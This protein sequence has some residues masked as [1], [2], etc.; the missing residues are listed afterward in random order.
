MYHCHLHIVFAGQPC[1]TF[2]VVEAIAPPKAFTYA[3]SRV[4]EFDAPELAGADLILANLT[5]ADPAACVRALAAGKAPGAQLVV[6]AGREQTDALT[7]LLDGL[8]DLWPLPMGEQESRFRFQRWQKTCR[9]SKDL[10]QSEHFLDTLINSTPSMVWFKDK[11][12]LHQKVNDSFCRTVCKDK[13]QVE[14]RDHCYIW[15]VGPKEAEV[16]AVSDQAVM[17]SHSICVSEEHVQMGPD[18]HILT[19]YKAPLYDLDGSVMG[20]VGIGIDATAERDYEQ[21][22]LRKT[23]AL[24]AI[25]TTLK[26]GVLCHSLDGKRIL[27]INRAALSI[28]DYESQEEM[29]AAGFSTVAPSVLDEDKPKLRECIRSLKKEGDSVDIE[30]RVLHKDGKLLHVIGN[31]KLIREND[32]LC[33]QRFLLDVTEQKLREKERERHQAELIQA[34]ARDYELVCYFDLSSGHGL[35]L[36]ADEEKNR[37]TDNAFVGKVSLDE[38]MGKYINSLVH[39]ADREMMHRAVDRREILAQLE[40]KPIYY[41]NYRTVRRGELR[42]FT[43]KI[44]RGGRWGKNHGIVLGLRNVDEVTRKEMEHKQLLEDALTQANLANRAKSSFLSNMSHDIRTPINAIV[45]FTSLAISNIDRRD[46]LEDYLKKIKAS[47]AHLLALIND[48]LDMSRIESGRLKLQ[49]EPYKLSDILRDLCDIVHP[50]LELRQQNMRL[51]LSG[52]RDD[53]VIC[54]KL[55]LNRVLMNIL[56]NS[57]KYTGE[58]G[59]IELAVSQSPSVRPGYA[60]YTFRV[61]DNGIGMSKEFLAHIFDPFEREKNTTASG[62]QG[63]GLGMAITKN[64]VEMMKGTIEIKS[65]Q[66]VGTRV[67]VTFSF[68]VAVCDDQALPVAEP[69][70]PEPEP[71]ISPELCS[72]RILLVEDNDLNQQIG[73]AILENA[74]F[75]VELAENGQVS[76]DM[77]KAAEPGYYKLI[78]MDVQMPVM[79]GYEAARAIR[80]LPDKGKAS[81]PILAMTANAFEEDRQEAL[82]SG[83]NDHIAKPIDVNRLLIIMSRYLR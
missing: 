27:S 60:D 80:A 38:S 31:V 50:D 67:L 59:T 41:V 29:L 34:L 46:L 15:N 18:T 53:E 57:I 4:R 68:R 76:V 26:C 73:Q 7:G 1:L 81:I 28:L 77:L 25:F 32:E 43:M 36:R 52:V 71:E 79:N 70:L 14:G 44:V 30:Y 47:S 23:R 42:Y 78:L 40:K 19:V 48:V 61:T 64:L 74:G 13:S 65:R 56:S 9:M 58:G 3:F 20:T 51:N 8:D 12:G 62:V 11:E 55:R 17:D 39:E 35:T 63:T 49:E 45:G 82:R 21:G 72:G 5:G 22:L 24:E 66:G 75:T 54:D 6:L 10:W 33:Y 69:G 83:M 2:D 16:C 37:L